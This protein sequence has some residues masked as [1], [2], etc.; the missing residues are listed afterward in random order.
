MLVIYKNS[1]E[2]KMSSSTFKH[3]LIKHPL[4]TVWNNIKRRCYEEKN[5][6][7]KDYGARGVVMCDEWKN[8]FISFYNWCITNDWQKGLEIEKDIK[9]LEAGIEPKMYSPEW[10]SII[11]H[12]KNSNAR[13]NSIIIEF[14][15][16]RFMSLSELADRLNLPRR[17]LYERIKRGWGIKKAIETPVLTKY[18]NISYANKCN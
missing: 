5:V 3:G 11:T 9:A 12:K 14:R 8:D 4:Y 7:Y 15:G 17:L 1:R 2:S 6:R 18:R 16:E 13:R 10:C